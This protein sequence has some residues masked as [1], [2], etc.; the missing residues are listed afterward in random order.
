MFTISKQLS[1]SLFSIFILSSLFFMI[2]VI[3]FFNSNAEVFS[4]FRSAF[5]S[6]LIGLIFLN[7]YC[8]KDYSQNQKGINRKLALISFFNSS[9]RYYFSLHYFYFKLINY[10]FLSGKILYWQ[11]SSLV[12]GLISL[13]AFIYIHQKEN[14]EEINN[15]ILERYTE[16]LILKYSLIFFWLIISKLPNQLLQTI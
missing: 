16:F 13:Y 8:L 6:I 4:H 9:N 11:I 15:Y 7:S 14:N 3:F 10:G 5:S 1:I 12:I 2:Q